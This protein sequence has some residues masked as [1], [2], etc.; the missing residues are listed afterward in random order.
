MCQVG[1]LHPYA[2]TFSTVQELIQLIKH[3]KIPIVCMCNDRNHP[4]IRSLSNYCFDLRFQRPR[5][6]QIKVS[7]LTLDI[8]FLLL[9]YFCMKSRDNSE[10]NNCAVIVCCMNAN[11]NQLCRFILEHFLFQV[12]STDCFCWR[13]SCVALLK[14]I[15]LFLV[16]LNFYSF[17]LICLFAGC[18]HDWCIDFFV[19]L[20]LQHVSCG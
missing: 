9:L 8:F 1:Y 20:S 14:C 18:R 12:P 4:K 3:S 10:Y 7:I 16:T 2:H 5:I 17:L 19:H 6:E 11:L 13:K 15:F